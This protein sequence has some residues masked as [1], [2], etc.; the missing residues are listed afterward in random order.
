MIGGGDPG[1]KSGRS[2]NRPG[3]GHLPLVNRDLAVPTEAGE[4]IADQG[5]H[6]LPDFECPTPSDSTRSHSQPPGGL[7]S[8]ISGRGIDYAQ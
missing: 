1:A 3:V 2:T 4:T 7:R 6:R 8:P 5:T